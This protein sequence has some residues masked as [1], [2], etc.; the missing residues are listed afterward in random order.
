MS[1]LRK[2]TSLSPRI[3]LGIGLGLIGYA[4]VA[5]YATDKISPSLGFEATD[6]D[7]EELK[8]WMPKLSFVD[9]TKSQGNSPADKRSE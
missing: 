1:L 4:S 9:N 6:K 7:T 5:M 3:R 2:F 8:R